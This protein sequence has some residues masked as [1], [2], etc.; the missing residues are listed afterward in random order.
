[1]YTIFDHSFTQIDDH[2]QFE[3]GEPKIGECLRFKYS[4]IVHRCFTFDDDFTIDQQS[5]SNG[6]A[7]M[8]DL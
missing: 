5:I 4:V 2:A 1:M 7:K 8:L 3:A 6:V